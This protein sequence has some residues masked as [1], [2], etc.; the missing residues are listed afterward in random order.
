MI[1]LS[2]TIDQKERTRSPFWNPID[3]RRPFNPRRKRVISPSARGITARR[4]AMPY[5]MSTSVPTSNPR[6]TKKRPAPYSYRPPVS[7][8]DEF[9][10]RVR[11]SGLSTNAFITEAVFSKRGPASGVRIELA[12]LLTACAEIKDLIR[13]LNTDREIEAASIRIDA[14]LR[15]IRTAL[16]RLLG[17]RS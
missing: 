13:S 4:K 1:S 16:M 12:Q 3:E 14:E 6:R 11:A 2:W 9:D 17:R 10:A 7:L 5:D 15:L 8:A